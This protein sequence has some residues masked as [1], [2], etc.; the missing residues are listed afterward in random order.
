MAETIKTP[1]SETPKIPQ[2]NGVELLHIQE[3]RKL[4]GAAKQFQ[5]AK[6]KQEV[7]RWERD[8]VREKD[9]A[10]KEF[11]D[12][13]KTEPGRISP[14]EKPKEN[15]VENSEVKEARN[16]DLAQESYG[17]QL[18][19]TYETHISDLKVKPEELKIIWAQY[20]EKSLVDIGVNPDS[21]N[22]NDSKFLAYAL[23]EVWKETLLNSE[24]VEKGS[25]LE[26][27]RDTILARVTEGAA[28]IDRADFSNDS[29]YKQALLADFK[30]ITWINLSLE[31]IAELTKNSE[32][33]TQNL[34]KLQLM[35]ALS[36]VS[37]KSDSL[38]RV[39]GF[40][41]QPNDAD[42][43]QNMG[44][45]I[46]DHPDFS[47]IKSLYDWIKEPDKRI[48]QFHAAAWLQAGPSTPW[49]M[50][51]IQYVLRKHYWYQWPQTAGA[52]DGLKIGK[53]TPHPG[54]WDLVLIPRNGWS[55]YHIAFVESV[56]GNQITHFW[57]NQSDSVCSKT[58]TIKS[59]MQFRQITGLNKTGGGH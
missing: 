53:S 3:R 57:G 8:S 19:K 45:I 55:G 25:K 26:K 48:N 7:A 34:E 20:L 9:D 24:W 37:W 47:Q 28:S 39:A 14:I 38:E 27:M 2:V 52:R 40:S 36:A 17:K 51:F 1:T 16:V 43:Q 22:E 23:P 12:G 13:F 15:F 6:M 29:E 18:R 31:E 11:L 4:D 56:Q 50:S 32:K 41:D 30:N 21:P 46:G 35:R 42:L 49:C 59:G 5:N 58:S 44:E 10:W 54:P 33:D